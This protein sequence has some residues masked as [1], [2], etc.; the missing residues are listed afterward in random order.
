[1]TELDKSKPQ[2]GKPSLPEKPSGGPKRSLRSGKRIVPSET[3]AGTTLMFVI[4]I[5]AFLACLT[6]GAVAMIDGTASRWQSDISREVTIQ[7]KPADGRVMDDAVRAAGRIAL[8]FEGVSR[9]TALN[10]AAAARLLE[11]WLGTGLKLEELPVPKLLMVSIADGASPDFDAMRTRIE[12]EIPG[13]SLDDHRAWINRLT[14]MAGTMVAVGMTVF[15]LVMAATVT[16]VVFATRGAMAGN[17]EVV[18][19][20][21]F[22]GADGRFISRQFQHHFLR[23]GFKGAISG[24]AGAI[25]LFILLGLWTSVSVATP[26]GDQVAALFGTFSPGW[27]GYLGMGAV[28]LLVAFLTGYTSSWTVARHLQTLQDYRRAT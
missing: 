21:H 13:A 24:G 10:D 11:P 27:A 5:M 25:V 9:V 20:L 7:I 17:R 1:M 16:T 15:L 4:A 8:E 18:E 22:V 3:I 19:V 26:E 6:L 14:T 12:N 23:L 28:I 2:T